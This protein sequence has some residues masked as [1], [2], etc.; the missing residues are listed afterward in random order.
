M[1]TRIDQLPLTQPMGWASGTQIEPNGDGGIL[2]KTNAG[3]AKMTMDSAGDPVAFQG[4][5]LADAS[6]NAI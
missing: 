1:T 3:T 2:I 5:Y 4:M 6:G